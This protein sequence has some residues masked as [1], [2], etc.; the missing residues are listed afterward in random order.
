M[1]SLSGQNYRGKELTVRRAN[2]MEATME[3]QNPD[4]LHHSL[5]QP[6]AVSHI[7]DRL[8]EPND[9]NTLQS[10]TFEWIKDT[11]EV[12]YSEAVSEIKGSPIAPAA[13]TEA[14]RALAMGLKFDTTTHD[15][16]AYFKDYT[17]YASF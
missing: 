11:G 14:R 7:A 2:E 15:L 17:V 5:I 1:M 8:S 4:T 16:K 6:D 10:R 3:Q 12:L 13:L 9:I